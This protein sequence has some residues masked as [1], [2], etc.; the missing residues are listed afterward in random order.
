MIMI[1]EIR[2]RVSLSPMFLGETLLR[3]NGWCGTTD[4]RAFFIASRSWWLTASLST[5]GK[6]KKEVAPMRYRRLS[7]SPAHKGRGVKPL[8]PQQGGGATRHSQLHQGVLAPFLLGHAQTRF[9]SCSTASDRSSIRSGHYPLLIK[10][11]V[12]KNGAG[13]S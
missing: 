8:A 4:Q 10:S 1:D 13:V 7:G 2:C 12:G 11:R 9:C 5:L 3:P 6:E